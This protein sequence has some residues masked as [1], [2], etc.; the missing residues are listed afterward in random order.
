MAGLHVFI[1]IKLVSGMGHTGGTIV[2]VGDTPGGRVGIGEAVGLGEGVAVT[3]GGKVGKGVGD[4]T[5]NVKVQAGPAAG[6][7]PGAVGATGV[8]RF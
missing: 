1:L 4:A 5:V 8:F 7:L 3:P 2:G 6:V